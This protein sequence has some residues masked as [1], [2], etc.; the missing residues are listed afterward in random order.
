M[1]QIGSYRVN[2]GAGIVTLPVFEI[3]DSGGGVYEFLRVNTPSGLG[4]I[5]MTDTSN[6]AHP[7]LR[8]NT[9]SYGVL[10][11]HDSA[12]TSKG[13]WV[14]QGDRIMNIDEN[15]NLLSSFNSLNGDN[16]EGLGIMPN[17]DIWYCTPY[18][19]GNFNHFR[20]DKNGQGSG[21]FAAVDE[22][23]GIDNDGYVWA[24][25]T[26]NPEAIYK[27]DPST[28]QGEIPA[29]GTRYDADSYLSG[30]GSLG[31]GPDNTIWVSDF[32]SNTIHQVSQNGNELKSIPAPG[33][34]NPQPWAV[35]VDSGGNIW[36]SEVGDRSNQW[37]YKLDSDGTVLDSIPV[38]NFS[39]STDL[40][41]GIGIQ[42]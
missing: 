24:A 8:I 27:Y 15:G 5:P 33:G 7:Y 1:G 19:S 18:S 39:G 23:V 35:G 20:V 13:L 29:D 32:D 4:F 2:T 38:S 25:T 22:G 31:V 36:V 42:D 14:A 40:V 28:E 6:A 16:V 3:G 10:A 37:I 12:S 9:Q 11:A 34:G 30:T 17:G 41:T 21:Q 26:A